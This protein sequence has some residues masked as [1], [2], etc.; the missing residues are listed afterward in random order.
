MCRVD[1]GRGLSRLLR[2]IAN[3]GGRSAILA[4]SLVL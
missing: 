1:L 4:G 3:L 2:D